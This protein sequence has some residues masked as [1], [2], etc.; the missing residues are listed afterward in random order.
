MAKHGRQSFVIQL[1]QVPAKDL[2][3]NTKSA[4]VITDRTHAILSNALAAV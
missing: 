3:G 1:P 2:F 4:A